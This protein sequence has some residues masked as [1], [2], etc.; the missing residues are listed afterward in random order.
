MKDELPHHKWFYGMIPNSAQGQCYFLMYLRNEWLCLNTDFSAHLYLP[1]AVSIKIFHDFLNF[2][3][4]M[5]GYN[6]KIDFLQFLPAH[7][8]LYYTSL[9]GPL[10][11]FPNQN[12]SVNLIWPRKFPLLLSYSLS[13]VTQNVTYLSARWI[14]VAASLSR[15]LVSRH[16]SISHNVSE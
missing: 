10:L 4:W 6:L 12:F 3:Q 15:T 8:F 7:Q 5:L 13:T 9:P 1:T 14:T 11:R 2:L 16:C